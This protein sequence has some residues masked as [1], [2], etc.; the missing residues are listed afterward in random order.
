LTLRIAYAG[1][2]QLAAQL[3]TLVTGLIFVALVTRN[4]TI[5][6]FGLWQTLGSV[7]G[8]LL[9]PLA[10]LSY[11]TVRYSARG[12]EVGRTSLLTGIISIPIF[13][14]VYLMLVLTASASIE[15]I[16]FFV[17]LYIIQ[18]PALCVWTSVKPIATA[19][20]PQY[21]GYATIALEIGKVLG[22][23]YTIA[24]LKLGLTGAILALTLGQFFQLA[25]IIYIIRPKLRGKFN[26]SILKEWYKTSWIPMASVTASRLSISDSIIVS[27]IL[28][29]TTVVGLFQASRLFTLIVRYSE[30]FLR[31]LNPKL[32]RDDKYE[33]IVLTLRLQALVAVPLVVGALM[34]SESLLGIL[35]IQYMQAANVLRILT[36]VAVLEGIEVLIWSILTGIEKSD[37]NIEN[38]QFN[39]LKNSWLIRIPLIDL[40]KYAIYFPTLAM[41]MYI[42]RGIENELSLS[43][44]WAII[45]LLVT[46]PITIY[47]IILV[48]RA[49]KLEVPKLSILTYIASGIVMSGFLYYY[50]QLIPLTK[51]STIEM[52]LYIIPPGIASV[53]I[54]SILIIIFDSFVRKMVKDLIYSKN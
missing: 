22:A 6:E 29:S 52:I 39:K 13:I 16:L 37:Q 54:Y 18:I 28:G 40:T 38:L 34:L 46:I 2:I 3:I 12:Y 21:L 48:N 42:S 49:I 7:V 53:S 20:K 33:D 44:Y 10:P 1:I 31:V 27:V 9:I 26:F 50:T 45:L 24:I 25:I 14:I 19:Y 17:L 23:Y 11:W 4:L 43:M 32:I 15:A 41:I 51:T 36:I 8:L 35:G 5:D 47:K 30:T